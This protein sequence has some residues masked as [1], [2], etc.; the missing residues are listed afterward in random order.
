MEAYVL[1]LGFIMVH[2]VDGRTITINPE[3][4][5]R[6]QTKRPDKPNELITDKAH[7]LVYLDDGGFITT[8]ETCEEIR[9]L[10][11]SR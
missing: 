10:E 7:C 8:E 5:T 1:L 2:S 6:M 4:I 9:Q 11:Q 3:H